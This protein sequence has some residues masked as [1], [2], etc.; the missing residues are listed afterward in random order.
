MLPVLNS[1]DEEA[2]DY[3]HDSDFNASIPAPGISVELGIICPLHGFSGGRRVVIYILY[4]L[5]M[6]E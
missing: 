1:V 5:N 2:C 3:R 6:I 4:P